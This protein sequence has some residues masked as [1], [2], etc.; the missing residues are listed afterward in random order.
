MTLISRKELYQSRSYYSVYCPVLYTCQICLARHRTMRCFF[1][2]L[3]P[4]P[5]SPSF[6]NNRA[7][8]CFSFK[9]QNSLSWPAVCLK[10]V[11]SLLRIRSEAIKSCFSLVWD[12]Y[13]IY[14]LRVCLSMIQVLTVVGLKPQCLVYLTVE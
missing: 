2:L 13:F 7:A 3:R 6:T 5:T 9:L 10:P 4:S 14:C 1:S 11:P 8:Y 12:F